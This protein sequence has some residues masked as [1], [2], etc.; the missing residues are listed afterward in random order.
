VSPALADL[1][2]RPRAKTVV[3]NGLRFAVTEWGDPAAPLV[4]CLHGFPVSPA[5]WKH[6]GP[7]IARAGYRVAAPAMR[8]YYP[9]EA[10]AD[11]DYSA[12]TLGRDA[13][14]LIRALGAERAVVIGHDWG[15]VAALAATT[16][17]PERVAKLVVVAIPHP[18]ATTPDALLKADHFLTY[19]W[20]GA[21]RRF[22]AD[23]A[24][25]VDAILRK[26]SPTWH[27]TDAE[28]DEAKLAFRR[29]DGATAAFGY[30]R[31]LVR[32][33]LGPLVGAP[34]AL[35]P[36]TFATPTLMI[37]GEADGAVDAKHFENSRRFFSGPMQVVG[38]A[39]AGHFPQQ[40]QPAAFNRLITGFLAPIPA[41]TTP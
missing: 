18:G 28:R 29:P 2:A 16:L 33:A 12:E 40:E 19:P 3:A 11:G 8:G 26:W 17:A 31:S 23:D 24:A 36:G 39:D 5:T 21:A 27:P 32:G 10:P 30:Y 34:A 13:L 14:A 35:K 6:L 38:L 25:G 15:A 9:T 41:P 37:Y 22:A 4:L 1:L 20:P 7:A